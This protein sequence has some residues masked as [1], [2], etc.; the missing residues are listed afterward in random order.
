MSLSNSSSDNDDVRFSTDRAEEEETSFS[1][2][3]KEIGEM[4]KKE[5]ERARKNWYRYT[6]PDIFF[7]TLF[8][9]IFA[10]MA[11][12]L[13]TLFM[14]GCD[15]PYLPWNRGTDGSTAGG[16]DFGPERGGSETGTHE[17][18]PPPAAPSASDG[19]GVVSVSPYPAG[20]M[21]DWCLDLEHD[22]A[23]WRRYLE[24][25][26]D[27]S[28]E[29]ICYNNPSRRASVILNLRRLVEQW[30]TVCRHESE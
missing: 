2:E 16:E 15:R 5:K 8:Y 10:S 28:H 18:P 26:Y 29:T 21:E 7:S 22:V 20:V 3:R 6:F 24:P 13:A 14:A 11:V 17:L 23:K 12:F 1:V 25:S 9:F 19:G 30:D 4:M 27:W